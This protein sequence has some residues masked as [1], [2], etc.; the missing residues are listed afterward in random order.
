L[1]AFVQNIF[2][3]NLGLND[4]TSSDTDYIVSILQNNTLSEAKM[5]SSIQDYL[6]QLVTWRAGVMWSTHGHTGVDVNL[7]S[8]AGQSK[9]S[10]LL[11][12]SVENNNIGAWIED[13]LVLSD[14]MKQVQERLVATK[15]VKD[16]NAKNALPD[17]V[18]WKQGGHVD[19][20]HY[21]AGSVA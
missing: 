11:G 12:A 14:S 4:T 19:D 10:N 5:R 20:I 3:Q 17:S 18:L 6:G 15:W 8:Y 16:K 1:Q 2:A 13:Y 7:Y 9:T 21:H